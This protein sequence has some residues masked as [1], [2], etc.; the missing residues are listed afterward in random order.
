MKTSKNMKEIQSNTPPFNEY[1]FIYRIL[2]KIC[3]IGYKSNTFKEK[4]K[5]GL[6]LGCVIL[7]YIDQIVSWIKNYHLNKTVFN[8]VLPYYLGFTSS[9]IIFFMLLFKRE[10]IINILNSVN[11]S[12]RH[13]SYTT[14]NLGLLFTFFIYLSFVTEP[15]I[16]HFAGC[17][18]VPEV[19]AY[20]SNGNFRYFA[21][22]LRI[23]FSR[24]LYPIFMNLVS[25]LFCDLCHRC[26]ISLAEIKMT[27]MSCPVHEFTDN[28][29]MQVLKKRG[30]VVNAIKTI[31][32]EFSLILSLMCCSEIFCCFTGLS[33]LSNIIIEASLDGDAMLV[34]YVLNAFMCLTAIVGVAGQI[35]IEMGNLSVSQHQMLDKVIESGRLVRPDIMISLTHRPD[36][37][38]SASELLF[39]TRQSILVIL[40]AFMTYTILIINLMI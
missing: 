18:E 25:L 7:I 27:I 21:S 5:D 16:R 3:I 17:K 34:I 8:L 10:R 35:S 31:Q 32:K 24:F 38:L 20:G 6:I 36:V 30:Q 4:L 33:I 11:L 2:H 39:F 22:I 37:T 9:I 12:S 28:F 26:T 14:I 1:G 19:V 15:I 23:I 13:K 29:Q 40:G